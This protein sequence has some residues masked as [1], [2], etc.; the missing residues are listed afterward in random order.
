MSITIENVKVLANRT[1]FSSA[2]G[3]LPIGMFTPSFDGSGIVDNPNLVPTEMDHYNTQGRDY[4]A[5]EDP[6]AWNFTNTETSLDKVDS[7]M[8]S[9]GNRFI[10]DTAMNSS[11]THRHEYIEF[12]NP[13]KL[14]RG[15]LEEANRYRMIYKNA[16]VSTLYTGTEM[17]DGKPASYTSIIATQ[18]SATVSLFNDFVAV[19]T[20]G[21]MENVPLMNTDIDDSIILKPYKDAG[22]GF[23]G[24]HDA[25]VTVEKWKFNRDT[26]LSDCSIKKL[27]ELSQTTIYDK[28]GNST[29]TSKLGMARYKWTDFMYCKDLGR[30]SNNMLITLRRFPHPIGDNIFSIFG[31]GNQDFNDV[32]TAPDIGRMI[33][34]L[35]DENKLEDIIKF[36]FQDTWKELHAEDEQLNSESDTTPIGQ[37]LN[38]GNP[39]YVKGFTE[40]RLGG[41]NTIL[42][43]FA[44][45]GN[46]FTLN[47]SSKM[48]LF[49]NKGTYEG[50]AAMNGSHY[51]VNKVYTKQGT[52][53]DTHI[54][55]GKLVFEHSFSLVF[56][57]QL[58]AYENINPKSAFLDLIGNILSTTY[59]KGTFWGGSRS[60]IGSPGNNHSK[61]WDL[62][63][64]LINEVAGGVGDSA[65]FLAKLFGGAGN[66]KTYTE[67]LNKRAQNIGSTVNEAI[68]NTDGTIAGAINAAKNLI[69]GNAVNIGNLFSAL[70]SGSLKNALG[71]PAIYAFKSL[72]SGEPVGLWHVTIGNPRNPILAMGNLIIENTS[73]QMY[74][75]LGIDDF[76]SGIKVTVSLKHAKSRDAA[77]IANMFTRGETSI[78]FKLVGGTS[79]GIP[80]HFMGEKAYEK[81]GTRDTQKIIASMASAT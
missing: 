47:S 61:G 58:K 28:D 34:W 8:S 2:A 76:P 66:W 46:S 65:E 49:D 78:L 67:K 72:L 41:Q 14:P 52:V 35:G 3:Q 60:L 39:Q 81:F 32:G 56:N 25:D 57:Y 7:K 9:N 29:G 71:R 4:V 70:T 16:F 55:E 12:E 48:K 24:T 18:S 68:G 1:F 74:G 53:Q 33:A 63:N 20:V 36:T 22:N 59:R 62:S 44:D 80:E 50:N 19:N 11:F 5:L 27:V 45:K 43:K 42:G 54:Y 26:D 23:N 17:K 31:Y 37:L 64:K 10:E 6:N 40:G 73:F 13:F 15:V 69:S 79:M 51:D 75:P 30:F 77:E 21:M 38:L